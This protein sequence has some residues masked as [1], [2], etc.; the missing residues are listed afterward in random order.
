V[1][2][3]RVPIWIADYVL[4]SYGTGAV[5]AVPAHDERDFEFA[6]AFGLPVRRVI[7]EDGGSPEDPLLGALTED[8]PMCNSGRFDG[9]AGEE[10]RAAVIAWLEETGRGE[11][12]VNYRLRDWLVSRQRYWGAPIPIVHCPDCGEVPVPEEQLP[13][14]L[15]EDVEFKPTGESPLKAH[16]TWSRVSC[17]RCGE[18]ARREVD[19]MDTFVDS[20]WYFLR[21]LSPHLESA[22]WDRDLA[23]R[24]LP[25]HQYVGG[26]EHAV[27]H[28][29]YARFV[30]KA[31]QR[32]GWVASDEPFARL[33]HQGVITNDGAR[34][35]KSRGNVINPEEYLERYGSDVLRAYLMFGFEYTRGGDWDDSGIHGIFRYLSRVHR[36]VE[37]NR[38]AL[39]GAPGRDEGDAFADL[40]YTFHN[41]I[42]GATTD[43]DRFQ[44]NTALSRHMELTNALYAYASARPVA[45]WGQ[46]AR[47]VVDAWIRLIAPFAPHLGEELWSLLGRSGSVFDAGWPAWDEAALVRDVVTVVLQVNGKVRDQMEVARGTDRGTLEQEALAFGRIPQWTA[48]KEIRRVII[49]PDKL[50]NI[51]VG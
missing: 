37:E 4:A 44:F 17:P 22:P 19:T 29:L 10:A 30:M 26:A 11:G 8:G 13:V 1:N 24:W 31:L 42:K 18:E 45:E 40:R 32:M 49:V 23:D 50:V 21:Y 35:S 36:L 14:E 47:D 25:V 2:G 16:P 6:H 46:E 5:M 39:A 15:P 20:S 3:E 33:V 7:L 28:L 9:L 12:T 48:G 41:S 38:G 43:L 34:M 27:M 51:V